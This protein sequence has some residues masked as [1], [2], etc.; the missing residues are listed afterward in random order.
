VGEDMTRMGGF[1]FILKPC[2]RR[3]SCTLLE[4]MGLLVTAMSSWRSSVRPI[5]AFCRSSVKGFSAQCLSGSESVLKE[6][7]LKCGHGTV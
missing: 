6:Q 4:E 1:D 7:I 3:D 5:L 2:S